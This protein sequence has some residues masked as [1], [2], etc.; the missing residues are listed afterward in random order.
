MDGRKV[1]DTLG[2]LRARVDRMGRQLQTTRLARAASNASTATIRAVRE[3]WHACVRLLGIAGQ[4]SLGF[5]GLF[6]LHQSILWATSRPAVAFEQG[7]VIVYTV[8]VFWN[9]FARLA[10]AGG[11]ITNTLVPLWNSVAKYTVEPFV[12]ITLDAISIIFTEH[13]YTGLITE[14][15]VPYHGYVCDPSD[16]VSMSWCGSFHFYKNALENEAAFEDSIVLGPG[17]ARRLQEATGEA[18]V[19]VLDLSSLIPGLKGLVSSGVTLTAMLSD[20]LWHVVYTILSE[21]GTVLFDTLI[22]LVKAA[23]DTL[24]L[25]VRS[26]M[27][28]SVISFLVDI[29]LILV[30]EIVIPLLIALGDALVCLLDLFFP[31]GWDAQLKCISESCFEA[32]TSD[33]LADLVVFTSAPIVW[34]RFFSILQASIN[35]NTG[36]KYTGGTMFG[37]QLWQH[38]AASGDAY[39]S[40]TEA[41]KSLTASRCAECFT[42]RVPELRLISLLVMTIVGCSNPSNVAHFMGGVEDQC[43]T[44]GEWYTVYACGAADGASDALSDAEWAATYSAHREHDLVYVQEYAARMA[45]RAR[46][47]GGSGTVD[48]GI[49]QQIADS[50]FLRHRDTAVPVEDAAA[51]VYRRTCKEVRR[52]RESD[53]APLVDEFGN[54]AFWTGP[55]FARNSEDSL[56][57]ETEKFL[58]EAYAYAQL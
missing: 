1:P 27:L 23:T 35:S 14:E 42:C 17:V 46:E 48:G 33:Q 43:Q 41:M 49:A 12:Y 38:D 9:S 15:Q 11:Q 24:L 30:I 34:E 37:G 19:P 36:R 4:L 57:Y 26:G 54:P 31:K 25:L 51:K 10:N 2:T 28:E 21:S 6:I 39:A 56:A 3:S 16:S 44:G 55:H 29:A 7:K 18:I 45:A 8:E 5:L 53:G 40:A 13:E 52:Q 50:W 47:K 58:Y 20:L 22:F 32:K